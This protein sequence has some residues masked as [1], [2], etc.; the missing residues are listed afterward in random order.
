MVHVYHVYGTSLPYHFPLR[1]LNCALD[2]EVWCLLRH[3]LCWQL[4]NYALELLLYLDGSTV[5]LYEDN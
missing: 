3:F 2:A 5:F 1:S 4:C